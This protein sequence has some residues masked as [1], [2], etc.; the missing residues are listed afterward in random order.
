VKAPGR[1][2]YFGW[3]VLHGRCW[4]SSRLR[5]HGLRDSDTC[6]L[7]AQE[8][9][10]LDHLLIGCVRSRETWFRV[11]RFY[12]LDHL[13][14]QEELSYFDW[15]L[16]VRKRVHKSQRKG[17]DCLALLVVWSLWKE[18]NLRNHERVALQPVS[19][20]PRILEEARRWARAGFVGIG[21]LGRRR[22]FR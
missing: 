22:L 16:A 1:C 6:A 17:F 14:P 11:L 21:S 9:K 4:T 13:T 10:T 8:V 15:C 3:L 7:C 18:R 2:H 19:L 12:G 20:A 5:R